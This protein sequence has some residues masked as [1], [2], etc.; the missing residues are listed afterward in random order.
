[1]ESRSWPEK[2]SDDD[3]FYEKKNPNWYE[4]KR[5]KRRLF[6][7]KLGLVLTFHLIN[8]RSTNS[9]FLHIDVQN[10]FAIVGHHI[11]EREPGESHLAF[12]QS[13]R[14]R[15]SICDYSKDRKVSN[16]SHECS[17]FV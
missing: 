8:F 16:K 17:K 13:K 7:K 9:K 3:F 10:R 14:K 6:L 11:V 1:M 2:K 5:Y 15:C 12:E 4:S